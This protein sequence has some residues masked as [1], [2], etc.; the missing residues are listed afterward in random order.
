MDG[1]SSS[2]LASTADLSKHASRFLLLV[3]VGMAFHSGFA[4]DS[5]LKSG[6]SKVAAARQKESVSP[7]GVAPLD[8]FHHR[9]DSISHSFLGRPYRFGPLGEGDVALG[10][11]APRFRTDS[12]DCVTYIE[13]M[14][15]LARTAK[16]D[17]IL[18]VLDHI[19]YDRGQVAWMHRNHFTESDWLPANTAAGHVRLDS[20]EGDSAD[21]RTLARAAFYGKRGVIRPDTTVIL[22][23][24]PRHKALEAFAKPA[25]AFRI[26]GI[27][28]VGDKY[29]GYAILHTGF[30]VERPGQIPLFRHASQAGTVR[31]QPLVEYLQ[32]KHQFSGIVVWSYLP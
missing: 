31:E 16:P 23:V 24:L 22:P 15:A 7:D 9:L 14:E 12:F 11:P 1:S 18:P 25:K 6:I 3:L 19:R 30:L 29:P 17:S 2:A 21:S 4:A 10:D 27:G 5:P 32:S 26:R 8:V 13:T 28:L 20:L